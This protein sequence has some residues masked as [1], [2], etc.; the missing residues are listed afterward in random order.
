ML[1]SKTSKGEP[2]YSEG[3]LYAKSQLGTEL[4]STLSKAELPM[5]CSFNTWNA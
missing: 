5:W 1:H 4:L 2:Q 3:I